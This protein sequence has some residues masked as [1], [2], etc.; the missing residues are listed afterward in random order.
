MPVPCNRP[1]DLLADAKVAEDYVE[2]VLDI[3]PA[4]QSRQGAGGEPQ[5]L[6]QKILTLG[7]W[8]SRG[9]SKGG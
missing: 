2:H 6:G 3:N 4:G 7:H 5:F 1:G 9:A 8:P